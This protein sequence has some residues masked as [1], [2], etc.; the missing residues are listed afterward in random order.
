MCQ[1]V[2]RNPGRE[3]SLLEIGDVML[4]IRESLGMHT[5]ALGICIQGLFIHV[6]F[7]VLVSLLMINTV[8]VQH[9]MTSFSSTTALPNGA[10]I[11]LAGSLPPLPYLKLFYLCDKLG[12]YC[13]SPYSHP[14][15]NQSHRRVSTLSSTQPGLHFAS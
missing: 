14:H 3:R 10:L 1:L 6:L 7:Y 2:L 4:I 8:L 11:T 12:A 13:L 5:F 9:E 15:W